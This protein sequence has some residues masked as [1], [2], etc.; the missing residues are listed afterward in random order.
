[1][2]EYYEKVINKDEDPYF[3]LEILCKKYTYSIGGI[4]NKEPKQLALYDSTDCL[5]ELSP[6]FTKIEAYTVINSE[7]SYFKWY[8][9]KNGIIIPIHNI[10]YLYLLNSNTTQLDSPGPE[11]IY[12]CQN[13][14]RKYNKANTTKELFL[15]NVSHE[16][17]TPLNGIVGYSQLLGQTQLD[18]TQKN[19]V[20]CINQCSIQLMKII[21]D[22]LDYSKLASGKMKVKEECFSMRE[23]TECVLDAITYKLR[24]KKLK[25][26]CVIDK[27]IPD[28][29][30]TDKQKLIQIIINIVSN[31]IKFTNSGGNIDLVIYPRDDFIEIVVADNGIGI[32]DEDKKNVFNE[33]SQGNETIA[34]KYGGTGLGLSIC[35][36]LVELLGGDIT[37]KSEYGKGSEFKFKIRYTKY[38]IAEM[39]IV[40]NASILKEKFVLAVD[41]N[42]SNRVIISEMLFD[43]GMHPI[44][45]ASALEA[46][47]FIAG[48]RYN[49]SMGLIDICMPVTNG[50]ELAKQIKL[51]QP[52]LPL[53]ALSSMDDVFSKT[54]SADFEEKIYKP[55]NKMQL[56]QTLEKVLSKFPIEKKEI[57]T[58]KET[59]RTIS[60]L[61]AEDV[62]YNQ[63]LLE[64]I[65]QSLGYTDI[66]SVSNGKEV[67]SELDKKY[68]DIVLLDLRMPEMDGFEV[69]AT[70]KKS[71]KTYNIVPVTASIVEEDREKCRE[72]GVTKFLTKPIDIRELKTILSE[73][74]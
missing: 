10:G 4:L 48:N 61:I 43:F 67:L 45:C 3:F 58:K 11:Y 44:V 28:Y 25:Y 27:A 19:Y 64:N 42:S 63:T 53:V 68:Y 15:A 7:K 33:Y 59:V 36:K 30:I 2:A 54:E 22:I 14:L 52:D 29:I 46:I 39:K 5:T 66:K 34:T 56:Y 21:N 32:S 6:N 74:N 23:V 71:K 31:S 24:E 57:K 37:F 49:F 16:I 50:F 35:K 13:I 47:R 20:T 55:I 69:I 60:I 18:I 17:R 65:L 9:P 8:K 72:F 26:K 70:L 62:I 12:I 38:E 73:I 41:D 40:K 51:E 1:M